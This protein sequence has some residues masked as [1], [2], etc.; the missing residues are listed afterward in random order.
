[1]GSRLCW[2]ELEFLGRFSMLTHDLQSF[3]LFLITFPN[4]F[5]IKLNLV[6]D[7]HINATNFMN[8]RNDVPKSSSKA[9]QHNPSR[10][11][12][13]TRRGKNSTG[14]TIVMLT[15]PPIAHTSESIGRCAMKEIARKKA[16]K[17]KRAMT[18]C[19]DSFKKQNN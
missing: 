3:L 8:I 10:R 1:M 13:S 17:S 9:H 4:L 12:G 18:V 6:S 2:F 14:K 19:F 15:F 5:V 11:K 16:R 7:F